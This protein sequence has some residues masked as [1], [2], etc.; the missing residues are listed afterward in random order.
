[1]LRSALWE[2]Q[3]DHQGRFFTARATMGVTPQLPLLISAL[4]QGAFRLAGEVSDGAIS[5]NCPPRYL[6]DVALPALR[7]GRSLAT[8]ACHSTPT[9]SQHQ[10]TRCSP[11]GA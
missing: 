7:A 2:G 6:L 9:C 8:R 11:T 4:G 5:W 1:V 3:L 10:A